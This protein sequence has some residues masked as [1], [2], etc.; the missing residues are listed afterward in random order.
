MPAA[1]RQRE[2]R[3]IILYRAFIY[4]LPQDAQNPTV[5]PYPETKQHDPHN[6]YLL[7]GIPL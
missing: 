6:P 7:Y 1:G 3:K 5:S 4:S 2:E